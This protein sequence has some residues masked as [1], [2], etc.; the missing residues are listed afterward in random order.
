MENNT[1][2]NDE[3]L[4]IKYPH[5]ERMVEEWFE[6]NIKVTKLTAFLGSKNINLPEN[7]EILLNTQLTHMTNYAEVLLNRINLIRNKG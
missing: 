7:E 3:K 2:Y 1:G 5:L 4:F 6:L